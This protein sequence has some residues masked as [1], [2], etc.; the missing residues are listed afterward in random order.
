[1]KTST[2]L[3]AAVSVPPEQALAIS[4]SASPATATV[5]R[6]EKR[7]DPPGVAA[8]SLSLLDVW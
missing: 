6:F 1:V 4:V 8:I 3:L 7:I 5:A 2:F